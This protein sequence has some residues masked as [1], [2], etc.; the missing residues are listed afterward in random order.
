LTATALAGQVLCQKLANK[1]A[2]E[3]ADARQVVTLIEEGIAM[4]R[5]VARGVHP[6]QVDAEGLMDAFRN[7]AA[8]TSQSTKIECA[9]E[10]ATPVLVEDTATATNF[11]RIGQEAVANAVRHAKPSRISLT[12]SRSADRLTLVVEDDGIGLPENWEKGPGLGTRI[13]AHRAAMIGA[14]LSIEPNPTG[15]AMIACSL[16]I[17]P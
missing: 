12:L 17:H 16:P 6:V 8:S 5:N 7:L 13:M 14:A 10:C 11:Y 4:A 3:D 15:G 9:F 1:A 2:P